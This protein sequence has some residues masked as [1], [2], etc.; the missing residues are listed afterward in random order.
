MSE[1][2]KE[3]IQAA[4][5]SAQE[6]L[7]G[8]IINSIRANVEWEAKKAIQAE[9][10]KI[11]SDF[12]MTEV[13]PELR[14]KLVGMRG[15]IVQGALDAAEQLSKEISSAIVTAAMK[16]LTE[17]RRGEIIKALFS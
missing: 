7:T 14:E 6:K 10:G 2:Y 8:E 15:E 5:T 16:N 17:Y 13:A 12:V 1:E 3:L 11:V 9:V 4:L